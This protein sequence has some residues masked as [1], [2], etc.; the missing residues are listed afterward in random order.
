MAELARFLFQKEMTRAEVE[1]LAAL[2]GDRG[3]EDVDHRMRR[4]VDS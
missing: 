2:L 1:A 3:S 4:R